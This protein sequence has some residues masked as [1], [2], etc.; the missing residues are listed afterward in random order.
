MDTIS[1]VDLA[2]GW[3]GL[4]LNTCKYHGLTEGQSH[5][6]SEIFWRRLETNDIPIQ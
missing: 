1:W 4:A 3:K 5:K 2:E 6:F